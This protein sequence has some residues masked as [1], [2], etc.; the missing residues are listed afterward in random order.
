MSIL[1]FSTDNVATHYHVVMRK[2]LK[3]CSTQHAHK[4]DKINVNQCN[5]VES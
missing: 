2:S 1:I 5:C 4:N 3:R